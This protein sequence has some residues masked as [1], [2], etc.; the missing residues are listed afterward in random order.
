[1]LLVQRIPWAFRNAG[2]I[3]HLDSRS[4]AKVLPVLEYPDDF[5]VPSN[6]YELRSVVVSAS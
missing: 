6:L 2:F 3:E 5:L 1:M 4:R